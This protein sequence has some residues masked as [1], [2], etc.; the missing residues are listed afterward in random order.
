[1]AHP[2]LTA[3]ALCALASLVVPEAAT[4]A[5]AELA[6]H[7]AAYALSLASAE[8]ASDIQGLDGALGIEWQAVCDGSVS[9]QLVRFEAGRRAGPPIYL[10]V[11]FTSWESVDGDRLRFNLRRFDRRGLEAEY[12]GE[13]LLGGGE[14]ESG[15]AHYEQPA[16]AE[17]ALPPGTIFPSEH[18]RRLI[19]RAL[20]G[21]RFVTDAVFDGTGLDALHQVTAV[22][23]E[24]TPAG[25]AAADT[26][27]DLSLIPMS[28]AFFPYE[29]GDGETPNFELVARMRS[30]GVIQQM[31]MDY[32]DFSVRAELE[33]LEMLPAPDC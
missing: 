21:E 25:A 23:G 9:Q 31:T 18:T 6:S 13:A 4:A 8:G 22:L 16:E 19:E 33:E 3:A 10:D 11:R 24:P 15:V 27:D 7:R 20:Q 28:L 29:G 32:G 12:R 14:D 30:D 2:S 26:A 5:P 17:L 1:M